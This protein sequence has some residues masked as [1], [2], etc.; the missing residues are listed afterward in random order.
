MSVIHVGDS[1]Q[2]IGSRFI[3][4]LSR[5][6]SDASINSSGT[7]IA[8][9]SNILQHS[10]WNRDFRNLPFWHNINCLSLIPLQ[11]PLAAPTTTTNNWTK[12][13]R[14]QQVQHVVALT[15]DL[16]ANLHPIQLCALE[17][18]R[19]GKNVHQIASV[20]VAEFEKHPLKRGGGWCGYSYGCYGCQ[21]PSPLQIKKKTWIGFLLWFSCKKFSR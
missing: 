14:N 9:P 19:G 17:E 18:L 3:D 11:L 16:Q 7:R 13:T 10:Y 15:T 1:G 12:D 6:I 4:Q 20:K 21:C 5:E 2:F 8:S